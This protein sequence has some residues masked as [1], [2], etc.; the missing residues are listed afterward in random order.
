[1]TQPR[2]HHFVPQTYLRYFS[3]SD[4]RIG[5]FDKSTQKRFETAT[6][7]IAAKRDFYRDTLLNDEFYWERFYAKKVDPLIPHTFDILRFSN[8]FTDDTCKILNYD[9]KEKLSYIIF[10]QIIRTKKSYLTWLNYSSQVSRDIFLSHE[11]LLPLFNNGIKFIDLINRSYL[12]QFLNSNDFVSSGM[13][14]L[15]SMLWLVYRIT[16]K[17]SSFQTSDNPVAFYHIPSKSCNIIEYGPIYKDCVI[18][19]PISD[20][21]CIVLCPPD[22]TNSNSLMPYSNC[23]LEAPMDLVNVCNEIQLQ[24]CFRQIYYKPY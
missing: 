24:Q 2:N 4:E 8:Y 7:N 12:L 22:C 5:V 10:S 17:S 23:I 14:S 6:R 11:D 18:L 3:A 1:M 9:L 19:F 20:K 13:K 21:L 16:N 15:L